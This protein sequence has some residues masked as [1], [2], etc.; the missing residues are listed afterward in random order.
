[1]TFF[2]YVKDAT[3][4]RGSKISYVHSVSWRMTESNVLSVSSNRH[5][6]SLTVSM[7]HNTG[8]NC[9]VQPC[10]LWT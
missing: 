5:N 6:K 4:G 10:L 9:T 8:C 2:V 3:A 7:P 1:M